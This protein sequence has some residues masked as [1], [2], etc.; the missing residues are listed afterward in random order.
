MEKML[1]TMFLALIAV[2]QDDKEI[3]RMLRMTDGIK[4]ELVI[5]EKGKL[6]QNPFRMEE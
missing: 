1:W 4:R 2:F 5:I 3:L 6:E